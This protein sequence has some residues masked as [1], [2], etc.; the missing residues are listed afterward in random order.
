MQALINHFLL[1]GQT[2]AWSCFLERLHAQR[3]EV[4]ESEGLLFDEFPLYDRMRLDNYA[5]LAT[6]EPL[7][8]SIAAGL[9]WPPQIPTDVIRS[10]LIAHLAGME[11]SDLVGSADEPCSGL[12]RFSHDVLR[13]LRLPDLDSHYRNNGALNF[14]PGWLKSWG[15]DR[16]DSENPSATPEV[17]DGILAIREIAYVEML[18]PGW[19]IV[20]LEILDAEEEQSIAE[21]LQRRADVLKQFRQLSRS[22]TQLR[23]PAENPPASPESEP[24]ADRLSIELTAPFWQSHGSGACVRVLPLAL[25]EHPY[26]VPSGLSTTPPHVY[27]LIFL[28]AL[29]GPFYDSAAASTVRQLK[30]VVSSLLSH[31][32]DYS[33]SS[34][35]TQSVSR[36]YSD[37]SKLYFHDTLE[38][39][40]HGT[41][42]GGDF[43]NRLRCSF[44][45]ICEADKLSNPGLCLATCFAAA[46]GLL[47]DE[48]SGKAVDPLTKRGAALLQPDPSKRAAAK[49]AIG[50]LYSF[51]N[52]VMHGRGY[53]VVSA[54]LK[55]SA[56]RFA[57]GV[58]IGAIH[59]RRHF[60]SCVDG[61]NLDTAK[62]WAHELDTA[63]VREQLV[64]GVPDLSH[65]VPESV[66]TIDKLRKGSP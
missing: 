23:P 40:A 6:F 14:W 30:P 58:L 45:M 3:A 9:P 49:R 54:E 32:V 16:F 53:G 46:E 36:F 7:V 20:D 47:G 35:P 61:E 15:L 51:R 12:R 25:L 22:K 62:D 17:P 26:D 63:Y 56:R 43:D 21:H 39:V 10:R 59:F 48:E 65:M 19:L 55:A 13:G 1:L 64:V 37:T 38:V 2:D 66:P 4:P 27:P 44:D 18:A 5:G 42:S 31:L 33:Q 28:A 50:R 57:V 24:E 52:E 41:P 29:D 11:I 8:E 60:T 34:D